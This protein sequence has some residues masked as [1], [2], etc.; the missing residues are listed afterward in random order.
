MGECPG[1]TL[2]N[3]HR[4][5]GEGQVMI[6]GDFMKSYVGGDHTFQSQYVAT[7]SMESL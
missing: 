5:M 7:L 2:M 6:L 4:Q 1:V 3:R